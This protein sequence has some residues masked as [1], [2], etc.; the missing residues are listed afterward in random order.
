MYELL[1]MYSM[2]WQKK[3]L[4]EQIEPNN[5]PVGWLLKLG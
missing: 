2:N 3:L 1:Y 5:D 4:K